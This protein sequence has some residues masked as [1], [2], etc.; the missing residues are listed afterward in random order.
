MRISTRLR[1]LAGAATVAVAA[2]TLAV[3][4]TS[5]A[6]AAA[7]A[8]T[9]TPATNLTDGADITV[10]VS[11]FGA[12]EQIYAAQCAEISA[13]DVVCNLPD[14]LNLVADASGNASGETWARRSFEGTAPSGESVTV[15]CTTVSGG[16]FFGAGSPENPG[17]STP[18]SFQ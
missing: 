9:V 2:L 14:A 18:I 3:S 1:P 6:L 8:V 13:G 11:G 7:P 17:T 16:C 10:S 15:D 4:G 12:G 5:P